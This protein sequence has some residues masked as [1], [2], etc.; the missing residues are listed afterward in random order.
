MN[1]LNANAVQLLTG[2]TIVAISECSSQ[3]IAL[4]MAN[5]EADNY[6]EIFVSR[7]IPAEDRA[8]WIMSLNKAVVSFVSNNC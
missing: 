2:A 4:S 6:A 1:T 8:T 7:E 3:H 5:S